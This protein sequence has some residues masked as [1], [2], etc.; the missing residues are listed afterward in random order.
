MKVNLLEHPY[1][2]NH[3]NYLC[4]RK[5]ELIT[6]Q[7]VCPHLEQDLTFTLH[8]P[9]SSFMKHEMIQN[10]IYIFLSIFVLH[11]YLIKNSKINSELEL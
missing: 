7:N 2:I 1:A 8:F 3:D 4:T 6:S 5:E 10:P 9:F 11:F